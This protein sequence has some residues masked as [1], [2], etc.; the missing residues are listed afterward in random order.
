METPSI[1]RPAVRQVKA[2]CHHCGDVQNV[3]A[4]DIGKTT[5]CV[6]CGKWF[7]VD[8]PNPKPVPR[9]EPREELVLGEEP[10]DPK[11]TPDGLQWHREEMLGNLRS[12]RLACWLVVLLLFAS[13]FISGCGGCVVSDALDRIEYR[14]RR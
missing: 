6:T 2:V 5:D 11:Q 4:T 8:D 3:L 1:K 7:V 14:L 12:I 9:P 13:L 10:T